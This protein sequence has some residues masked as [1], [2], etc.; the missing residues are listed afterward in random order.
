M[1]YLR[2]F[3]ALLNPYPS[4]QGLH[5]VN[6]GRRPSRVDL[7]GCAAAVEPHNSLYNVKR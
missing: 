4:L 7:K 3:F 1:R 6:K 2:R 5:R